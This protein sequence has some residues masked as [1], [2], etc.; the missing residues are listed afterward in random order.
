[1]RTWKMMKKANKDMNA[2]ENK[3]NALRWTE[4]MDEV[5]ID[6]LLEQEE[7][8]NRVDGTFTSTAYSNVVKKCTEKIGYPFDKDHIKNWMKTLKLNFNAFYDLFKNLS[9][10]SWSP[11]T[12]L[13][14]AEPEVW[15]ALI[16]AKPSASKWR[17]TKIKFYKKLYDLFA[18]DRANG[19]GTVSAKAKVQGWAR[20]GSSNQANKNSNNNEKNSPMSA[21]SQPNS[22]AVTSSRGTKRKESVINLFEKECE[23]IGG[24]I[25]KVAEAIEKGNL[26]AERGLAIVE[27]RI[28]IFLR[29]LDHVTIQKMKC[30]QNC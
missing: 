26:V 17:H 13:F 7:N 16:E 14:E 18:K 9:G 21:S 11:E 15:K 12:K 3:K 25:N 5:L 10:F 29:E 24:G 1:M 20:D 30:L 4:E 22:E 23:V 28:A 27:K 19:D 6:A 2:T 8:G